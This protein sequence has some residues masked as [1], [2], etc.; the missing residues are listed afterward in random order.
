MFHKS[1]PGPQYQ[2][3]ACEDVAEILEWARHP[4][5]TRHPKPLGIPRENFISNLI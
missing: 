5:C 3:T 4:H 2:R 1:F